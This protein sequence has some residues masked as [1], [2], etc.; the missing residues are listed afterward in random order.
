LSFVWRL[1]VRAGL[2]FI[3]VDTFAACVGLIAYLM[4]LATLV[5]PAIAATFA[6]IFNADLFYSAQM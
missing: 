4:L 2:R 6:L 1:P 5:H 3:S